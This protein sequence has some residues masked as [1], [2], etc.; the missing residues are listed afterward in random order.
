VP[1]RPYHPDYVPFH[2]RHWWAFGGG[3]LADFGCHFMDLPHWALELR[4][5]LTVE[6]QGQPVHPES[7]PPWLMVRYEY[8]ARGSKPPV[9]L[10]WYHGGKQP[11]LLST[12]QAAQW[13]SGVLFVGAKGRVLAD[14]NRR[15]L[16][17]EREFAGFIPPEP[18]IKDSIGH[19]KEWIE[20]CKIGGPTTCSFDYSGPLTEAAL[21]GNVAY[22]VG[23]K[24]EWNPKKLRAMN[25]PEADA[26]IRH[27]YR[28]GWSI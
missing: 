15:Q 27:R 20:A 10:T 25:C 19:H 24:L 9:R 14:Y 5:P 11:S 23:K 7:T 6:A 4:F 22:R 13:K 1:H 17:P 12:E 21:L 3:A 8:P 16:L 2:W 28:K 26:F 18:F